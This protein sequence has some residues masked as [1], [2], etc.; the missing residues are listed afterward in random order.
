MLSSCTF[1]V[2]CSC[3]LGVLCHGVFFLFCCSTC[4]TS[5]VFLFCCSTCVTDCSFAKL[6]DIYIKLCCSCVTN[7]YLILSFSKQRIISHSHHTKI[8]P[9]HNFSFL[10]YKDQTNSFSPSHRLQ[11]LSN[12][13]TPSHQTRNHSNSFSPSSTNKINLQNGIFFS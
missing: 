10:P 2:L 1:G 9:F 5:L 13:F 8:K 4:V 12:S 11:N 7:S 6:S 3:S